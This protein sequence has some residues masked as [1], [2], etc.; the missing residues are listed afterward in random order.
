MLLMNFSGKELF[1]AINSRHNE[2]AD[3]IMY[4]A[5]W[6]GEGFLIT[7]VLLLLF[8]FRRFQNW[9]YFFAALLCNL[10]PFFI[11]QTVKSY[12]DSP[13]P[14]NYFRHPPWI[15]LSPNW[16]ELLYRSFPSGHS[17]GAFSFFCFLSLLL[18]V[19]YRAFGF[20][21]FILA[22]LVCY[23]RVYLAAHFF[24]DVY[25]G[26]ILG[27]V[28]CIFIYFVINK[29]KDLFFKKKDTFI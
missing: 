10:I 7:A 15:H 2:I 13:R 22:L 14:I 8:A 25:V 24:S 9:W 6:M 3:T 16:P 28:M 19:R 29:I 26:S 17:E 1:F 12:F 21:F 23:S 11:E 4:Y 27:T 5:T 20:L 18:P